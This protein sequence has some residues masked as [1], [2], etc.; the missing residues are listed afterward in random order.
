[1]MISIAHLTFWHLYRTSSSGMS[2]GSS[3]GDSQ[4]SCALSQHC[5]DSGLSPKAAKLNWLSC[6]W[7]ILL[8]VV[9]LYTRYAV[10]A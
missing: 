8:K 7:R 10:A 2:I 9:L 6:R 5:P 4:L 3:E 1:M